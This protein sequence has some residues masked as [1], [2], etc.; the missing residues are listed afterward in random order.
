MLRGFNFFWAVNVSLM[1]VNIKK[2]ESLIENQRR[3]IVVLFFVLFFFLGCR[4]LSD[5]GISF[6][7]PVSRDNGAISLKYVLDIIAPQLAAQDPELSKLHSPLREYRD[8]DYGVAFDLPA[9]IL[10]RLLQVNDSRN[11]Y[12]LRHFL[13]FV[14]FLF[15]LI[16][17]YKTA[18]RRFGNWRYGLLTVVFMICSPRIFAE[19]F[20]NSKD[21]VFLACCAIATHTLIE[22][23]RRPC[24]R[25]AML[26][27]IATAIAIDIRIAAVIFPLLTCFMLLGQGL[28]GN[29]ARR[30]LFVLLGTYV[31]ITCFVVYI[32]WPWLWSQP[33][34]NFLLAFK[35]MSRFRW[36]NF[37]L[38]F[39][40]FINA[41]NL[42]W[43]YAPV[44]ILITTP[45]LYCLLSTFSII[46]FGFEVIRAKFNVFTDINISQD[47]V[48][49]VLGCG[50]LFATVALGS[51][52]YDGWRQLYFIYPSIIFLAV[53]AIAYCFNQEQSGYLKKFIISV[54]VVVQLAMTV[55]WMWQVHPYQNL[56]FNFIAPSNWRDQF[57]GDYWGL[58]NLEGIR[59]I[60]GNDARDHIKIAPVGATSLNQ[61][62]SMLSAPDRARIRI[63][64]LN[65]MPD[66]AVTNF[67]FFDGFKFDPVGLGWRSIYDIKVDGQIICT[68]FGF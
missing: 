28:F 3:L 50:P 26:H 46:R 68:V 58:S 14:I 55:S 9:M 65:D 6:D 61:S 24:A 1:F 19:S 36:E 62:V 20:Y 64:S 41:T 66:Y 5:Y 29:L 49:C 8:R 25:L 2:I 40:T 43:H 52:L 35:N 30:N 38:Y 54:S 7:E 21:V 11:Q 31:F 22:F 44:W 39:G 32:L 4:L 60:L 42:P 17:L 63:V 56:Y 37:N 53:K 45:F 34:N 47:F 16:A 33:I 18:K 27:G 15:G 57:E 59:Y 48:F 13:T 10:E 23:L 51:T 12:L 67:R